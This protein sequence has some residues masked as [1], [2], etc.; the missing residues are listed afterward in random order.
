MVPCYEQTRLYKQFSHGQTFDSAGSFVLFHKNALNTAFLSKKHT[1]L[2][3]CVFMP[4][5]V[6][7]VRVYPLQR[8]LLPPFES[9][10]SSCLF[11]QHC[12]FLG[13]GFLMVQ[14][15]LTGKGK[16]FFS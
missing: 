8:S 12:T 11:H 1:Y 9:G 15:K 10:G 6:R 16:S 3:V 13:P 7:E 14:G 4:Q 2:F 5:H